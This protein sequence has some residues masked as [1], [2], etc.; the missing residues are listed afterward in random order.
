VS[1]RAEPAHAYVPNMPIKLVNSSDIVFFMNCSF[2]TAE[3]R[4]EN[5]R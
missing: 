1:S 4:G 5:F 3:L 2:R